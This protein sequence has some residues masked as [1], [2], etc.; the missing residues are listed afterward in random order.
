MLL[1][2]SFLLLVIYFLDLTHQ[3]ASPRKEKKLYPTDP[4]LAHLPAAES[5]LFSPHPTGDGSR[6]SRLAMELFRTREAQH[7]EAFSVPRSLFL[8]EVVVG[9][10]S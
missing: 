4:L 2:D 6:Q 7:Q 9:Q 8:L 5:Y 3:S 10:R 1:A